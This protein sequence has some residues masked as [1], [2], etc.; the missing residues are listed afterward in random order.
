M[1]YKLVTPE[2]TAPGAVVVPEIHEDD[3][4]TSWRDAK[5]ALRSWH[6]EQAAS[7]RSISENDYFKS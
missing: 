2:P 3:S 4:T 6:L 7:L 5:K 1:G